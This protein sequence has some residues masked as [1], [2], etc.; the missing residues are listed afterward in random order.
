MDAHHL[1]ARI[2]QACARQSARPWALMVAL[3]FVLAWA[4]TGPFFG[5]SNAWQLIINSGTSIV[6]FVMVFLIQNAQNRDTAAIQLKLDEL[7]RATEGAKNDLMAL[8][9]ESED[10]LERVQAELAEACVE[11][12]AA[13]PSE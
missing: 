8:E 12:T 1:T 13:S 3:L 9:R 11:T 2:A 7:I 5:F 6:T 10:T 4:V